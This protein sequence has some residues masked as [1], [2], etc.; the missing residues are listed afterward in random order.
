MSHTTAE[1]AAEPIYVLRLYITGAS[2]SSQRAIRNLHSIC[3]DNLAGRFDLEVINIHHQPALASSEQIVAAPTLV[4]LRPLP[5]R[6]MIGD[7]SDRAK[8]L[9]GLGVRHCRKAI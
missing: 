9:A 2:Q 8:V 3:R 5:A 6:R 7:L 4:K 1:S